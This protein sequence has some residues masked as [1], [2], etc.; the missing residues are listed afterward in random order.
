MTAHHGMGVPDHFPKHHTE[1]VYQKGLRLRQPL[2]LLTF[3]L[4]T[5]LKKSLRPPLSHTYHPYCSI[6]RSHTEEPLKCLLLKQKDLS[7]SYS[8]TF[9]S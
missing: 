9:F 5:H 1:S 8:T 4:Y 7:R 2:C 3:C 6:Y